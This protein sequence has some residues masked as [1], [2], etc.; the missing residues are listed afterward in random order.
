MNSTQSP[1]TEQSNGIDQTKLRSLTVSVI[2][3]TK[4]RSADLARTIETLLQQTVQPLELIIVDQSA[5]PT[6]TRKIKI[7]TVYIHDPT[8]SGLTAARNNSM[9]V[10]R[11]DIWLFLDDDVLLEPDFIEKMLEAYDTNVTG[12]SGIITNYSTPALKQRLWEVVFQVGPFRDERQRVYR[13][14]GRLGDAE[15]IRVRQLGG[16]LMSFRAFKIR[17]QLFDT[18]L[19]GPCPGED[20]EF[21]AG[22]PKECVLR[23]AP[24]ARLI[25]NRSPESRDSTHWI[26]VDAQ[27]ASYMRERHWKSGMWNNLSYFWLSVGYAT[28]AA[29]SS[30]KNASFGPWNAWQE[31]V[32]RGRQIAHGLVVKP[33]DS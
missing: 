13:D 29:F 17:N 9:K 2:I 27:V 6:F 15:P 30:L 18:N 16:G 8:L 10:A 7:P 28:V 25:H 19:T 4:D 12:V 21:C 31:G 14:V 26:S 23:I 1:R 11:G 5:E 33:P 32:K 22:L 24:K 3:P 20:I